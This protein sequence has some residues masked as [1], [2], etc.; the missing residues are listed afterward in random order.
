[1]AKK[2]IFQKCN[3]NNIYFLFY[4][5]IDFLHIFISYSLYPKDEK[6]NKNEAIPKYILPTLIISHLY[7]YNISDFLAI[8]PHFIRKAIIKK[9][10]NKITDAQIEENNTENSQLIYNDNRLSVA[11]KKKKIMIYY[12]IFL[13][14]L[15]FLQKFVFVLYGIIYEGSEINIYTFSCYVPF[16]IIF[17]FMCSYYILKIHFYKLQKFS[18]FLNLGIFIIILTID[19]LN[20]LIKHSFDGK[21]YIFYAFCV[22]FYS[23]EY[24][25]VKKILLYG[26]I[27]IYL[28]MLIKGFFLLILVLLFSL[29]MFL[30]KKQVFIDIGYFFTES[31]LIWLMIGSI[32]VKFFLGLFLWIIIDRFSPNYY[33]FVLIFKEYF[34]TIFDK[35]IDSTE[36]NT[37]KWDIFVRIFL[38]II[39]FIGVMIHNEIVVINICNLGSDTK[40]FLDLEVKSEEQFATTD[41]PDI[42]KRY[43]T[44]EMDTVNEENE[45]AKKNDNEIIS[46]GEK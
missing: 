30:V 21:M 25:Y 35:L 13:A 45:E 33:P 22:I 23:I 12:C 37:M 4:I 14:I 27:S 16:E 2:I 29:I 38:Y 44:F 43:E 34:Y 19:L 24:S 7:T 26:Y 6:D 20:I 41:N 18:L 39:S 3:F 10:E 1:M 42:I 36:Y 8:I 46:E 32:F 17:Q 15:D 40:Y 28:L 31:K 5:I 9:K 11:N